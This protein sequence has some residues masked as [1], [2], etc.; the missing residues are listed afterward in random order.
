MRPLPTPPIWRSLDP[1][2]AAKVLNVLQG[3][4]HADLT[5]AHEEAHDKAPAA[6][7]TALAGADHLHVVSLPSISV[8]PLCLL[9]HSIVCL[10]TFAC[11]SFAYAL[12]ISVCLLLYA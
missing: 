5:G 11:F 10:Y 9:V 3:C 6:V 12:K 1:D 2:D 4:P 7:G 8:C